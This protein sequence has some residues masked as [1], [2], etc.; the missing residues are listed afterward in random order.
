MLD[1]ILSRFA[2]PVE[3]NT[4]TEPTVKSF[5]ELTDKSKYK[6]V[7]FDLVNSGQYDE[8]RKYGIE[9]LFEDESRLNCHQYVA[10]A[11]GLVSSDDPAT[12]RLPPLPISSVQT[13]IEWSEHDCLVVYHN[14]TMFTSHSGIY[15]DGKVISKW[16][17]GKNPVFSHS[18]KSFQY[19]Y[20]EG[21][22]LFYRLDKKG[23]ET[24]LF[25]NN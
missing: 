13:S 19:F 9:F 6:K 24:R 12:I 15:R 8:L 23:L 1:F 16:G 2:R 3:G 25:G 17:T 5:D 21:P 4:I 20:H 14:G 22:V 18:V 10:V 11:L 7:I